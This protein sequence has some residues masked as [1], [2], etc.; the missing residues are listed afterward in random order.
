MVG[1]VVLIF[2]VAFLFLVP[3][4]IIQMTLN[5]D[6]SKDL[7]SSS[8]LVFI[9]LIYAFIYIFIANSLTPNLVSSQVGKVHAFGIFNPFAGENDMGG[10]NLIQK[11][12]GR[13]DNVGNTIRKVATGTANP[14]SINATPVSRMVPTS[15][16]K[17]EEIKK[18]N[19]KKPTT[20]TNFRNY[21]NDT[22]SSSYQESFNNKAISDINKAIEADKKAGNSVL[23]PTVSSSQK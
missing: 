9:Y 14:N 10:S 8:Q 18:E 17:R 16:F 3:Q 13:I 2:K 1:S 6:I 15:A 4:F 5:L 19:N 12:G 20:A 11:V 21:R 22:A 7:A 23:K